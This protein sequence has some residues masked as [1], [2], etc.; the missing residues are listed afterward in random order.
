MRYTLAL[1]SA[2]DHQLASYNMST[3]FDEL[4][5]VET[6][7]EFYRRAPAVPDAH[8][9]LARIFE[10]RGDELSSLRHMRL[11]RKLVDQSD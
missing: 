9:N 11:Y 3:V 10:L 1:A 4:D 5:E 8:Y 2:P 6:A 7:V